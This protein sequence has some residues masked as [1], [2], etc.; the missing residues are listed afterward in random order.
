MGPLERSAAR[1]RL[2]ERSCLSGYPVLVPLI[3]LAVAARP[4][5]LQQLRGELFGPLPHSLEAG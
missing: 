4:G 1:A 3:I 5:S 2:N